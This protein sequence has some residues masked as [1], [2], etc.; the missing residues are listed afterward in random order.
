MYI[1]QDNNPSIFCMCLILQFQFHFLRY[2]EQIVL[3]FADG[4]HPDISVV[5][6]RQDAERLRAGGNLSKI[7]MYMCSQK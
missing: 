7:V 2:Y 5:V 3:T 6:N 4:S 1:F